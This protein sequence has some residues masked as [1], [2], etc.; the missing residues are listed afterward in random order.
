MRRVIVS[1]VSGRTCIADGKMLII[2]GNIIVNPG[3]YVWTDERCVYGNEQMGGTPMILSPDEG[4]VPLIDEKGD[5]AYVS[6]TGQVVR[7]DYSNPD[8]YVYANNDVD[9]VLA[10]GSVLD[11]EIS[12]DA[13]PQIYTIVNDTGIL[14]DETYAHSFDVPMYYYLGYTYAAD[15]SSK[16]IDEA[17]PEN[18]KSSSSSNEESWS[19]KSK[20]YSNG[21]KNMISDLL[22]VS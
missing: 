15:S 4:G 5:G 2:I 8:G 10:S 16:Y 12:A 7:T 20:S 9:V 13:E 3:D 18:N 14:S 1:S 11:A 17:H 6:E 22:F 21:E 19:T